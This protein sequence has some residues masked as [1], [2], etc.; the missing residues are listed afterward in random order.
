M[1][2]NLSHLGKHFHIERNSWLSLYL[3]FAFTELQMI[4]FKGTQPRQSLPVLFVGPISTWHDETGQLLSGAVSPLPA[5]WGWA[6]WAQAYDWCWLFA[7]SFVVS[8]RGQGKRVVIISSTTESGTELLLICHVQKCSEPA[9][10]STLT[11]WDFCEQRFLKWVWVKKMGAQ[12]KLG[13]A[14]MTP[15]LA[16][17][18]IQKIRLFHLLYQ[19]Q[20]CTEL[21]SHGVVQHAVS[22]ANGSHFALGKAERKGQCSSL[23]LIN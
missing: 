19:E 8:S 10:V 15:K 9:P 22:G 7:S 14:F 20:F 12:H 16:G 11:F 3:S 1:K 4:G 13:K 6:Q 18:D 5:T 21:C 23:W 2:F 17:N